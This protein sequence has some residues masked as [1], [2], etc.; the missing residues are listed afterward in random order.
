MASKR[1]ALAEP[2]KPPKPDQKPTPRRKASDGQEMIIR[3][4]AYIVAQR[5]AKFARNEGDEARVKENR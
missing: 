4:L 5:Q 3:E 2:K 1:R